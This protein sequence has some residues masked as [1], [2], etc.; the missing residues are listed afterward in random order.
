M[1]LLRG[2]PEV[3]V[4]RVL[5]PRRSEGRAHL[6]QLIQIVTR[7][8]RSSYAGAVPMVTGRGGSPRDEREP[9]RE[10]SSFTLLRE[11]IYALCEQR[12]VSDFV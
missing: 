11:R 7:R 10:R 1:L 3:R 9:M 8:D 2:L 5:F 6:R 4:L 12:R